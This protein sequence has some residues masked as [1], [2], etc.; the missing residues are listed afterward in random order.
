M[1]CPAGRLPKAMK[2]TC[3]GRSCNSPRRG[4]NRRS[5]VPPGPASGNT[6]QHGHPGQS[7]QDLPAWLTHRL[8]A[9]VQAVR[10]NAEQGV[11]LAKNGDRGY[12]GLAS[13]PGLLV[14]QRRHEQRDGRERGDHD[15]EM[16]ETVPPRPADLHRCHAPAQVA[17][18]PPGIAGSGS[19]PYEIENTSTNPTMSGREHP[20]RAGSL[21]QPA[22]ICGATQ[23]APE[24]ILPQKPGERTRR[25]RRR[26]RRKRRP[27][28]GTGRPRYRETAGLE[29]QNEAS[30][31]PGRAA[32]GAE[33][34][35]ARRPFSLRPRPKPGSCLE[36]EPDSNSR[37]RPWQG[38]ALPTELFPALQLLPVRPKPNL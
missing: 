11:Q 30:K 10:D 27:A 35:K 5:R 28:R 37:P 21:R 36:R 29:R 6:A 18:S 13:H 23:P 15:T 34:K 22:P 31:G 7:A 9:L 26:T 33:R 16:K 14:H 1:R 8:L 38:R 17:R 4:G 24:R 12:R 3:N 32:W 19:C 2:A 25:L 20:D